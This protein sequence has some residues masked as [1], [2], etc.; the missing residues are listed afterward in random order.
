MKNL[1]LFLVAAFC[2]LT[3]LAQDKMMP[4]QWAY[5]NFDD[6]TV[7]AEVLPAKTKVKVDPACTYAW[8]AFNKIMVTKGSYDGKL[9]HGVYK[10]FYLNNNLK[11]QGRYSKGLKSAKWIA[12]YDNGIVKETCYWKNGYK[13]GT[14]EFYNADGHIVKSMEYKDDLLNGEVKTF[15]RGELVALQKFKKGKE[16]VKPP[17]QKKEKTKKPGKETKPQADSLKTPEPVNKKIPVQKDSTSVQSK[18]EPV[19]TN[20][21][22]NKEGLKNKD[23]KK[24]N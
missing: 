24:K 15:D 13:N 21:Q 2:T 1:L 3:S 18:K 8:Y 17:V 4:S 5:I 14:N 19:K 7:K 6:Y 10:A 22:G 9:L 20:L 16:I 12:W 23:P 11:E